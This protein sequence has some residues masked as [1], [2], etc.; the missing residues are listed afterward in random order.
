MRFLAREGLAPLRGTIPGIEEFGIE[1]FAVNALSVRPGGAPAN[2]VGGTDEP[3]ALLT[4]D[5]AGPD[6]GAPGP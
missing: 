1:E 3:A 6:R 5:E 4:C 2:T